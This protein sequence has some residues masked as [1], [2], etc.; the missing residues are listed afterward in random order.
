MAVGVWQ[1]DGTGLQ[2]S[3]L[4]LS[5]L[6]AAI[7]VRLPAGFLLLSLLAYLPASILVFPYGIIARVVVDVVADIVVDEVWT[8]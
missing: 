2:A 3:T 6:V 4:C 7:T 5:A 1:R 8:Q